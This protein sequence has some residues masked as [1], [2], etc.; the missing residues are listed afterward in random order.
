MGKP[1][2]TIWPYM[3]PPF[4]CVSVH[5]THAH[6]KERTCSSLSWFTIS[7][8]SKQTINRNPVLSEYDLS[9]WEQ[10]QHYLCFQ[11]ALTVESF[12]RPYQH[13][14]KSNVEEELQ[15]KTKSNTKMKKKIENYLLKPYFPKEDCLKVNLPT[16]SFCLQF[17][18]RCACYSLD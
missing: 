5:K 18:G 10:C 2:C 9:Q 17:T 14:L 11:H 15:N 6:N 7:T 13:H 1:F 8:L 3:M 12:V 4:F 16:V